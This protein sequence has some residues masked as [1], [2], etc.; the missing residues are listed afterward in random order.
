[1]RIERIADG[2]AQSG[3]VVRHRQAL[4]H[5]GCGRR[6]ELQE[7]RR[8]IHLSNI[9][10]LGAEVFGHDLQLGVQVHQA[11]VRKN[12][13]HR[14]AGPR[15]FLQHLFQLQVVNEPALFDQCQQRLGIDIGH[16]IVAAKP[17]VAE[18]LSYWFAPPAPSRIRPAWPEWFPGL[19]L[20]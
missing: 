19:A 12:L 3:T 9:H 17:S 11:E 8:V 7:F 15:V 4:V 10:D 2:H 13:A 14:F 18:R 20:W 5:A 16:T 1:M 6:N